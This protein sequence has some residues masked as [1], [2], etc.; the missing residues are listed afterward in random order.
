MSSHAEVVS[1]ACKA[2]NHWNLSHRG[3]TVVAFKDLPSAKVGLA[4]GSTPPP[5]L[6]AEAVLLG[7]SPGFGDPHD[8]MR[9]LI[10][11]RL[12]SE[13]LASA[14]ELARKTRRIHPYFRLAP[15]P[16]TL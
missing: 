12:S 9:T 2:L 6:C 13:E 3:W 8:S 15:A 10:G 14:M 4:D 11:Q 1:A 7:F 16:A 5:L